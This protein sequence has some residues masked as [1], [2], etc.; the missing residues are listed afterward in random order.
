MRSQCQ[1]AL[2]PH[3][4]IPLKSP[5]RNRILR[6]VKG[7]SLLALLVVAYVA[8]DFTFNAPPR[9]VYQL[10][11]PALA[12]NEPRLLQQ[13]SLLVIV[14]R[15]DEVALDRMTDK[16]RLSRISQGFRNESKRVDEQGYFVALAYGTRSSCPL[17]LSVDSYRETCSDARYDLLGRSLN[18]QDYPDLEIPKYTFNRDHSVLTIE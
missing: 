10:R 14:A 1:Q 18:K 4:F 16:G 5:E 12:V 17:K 13:D 2:V 3:F 9:P 11:V 6:W 15:F 7:L 8:V